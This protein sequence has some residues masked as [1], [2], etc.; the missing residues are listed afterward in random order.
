MGSPEAVARLWE[1]L[2]GSTLGPE[3]IAEFVHRDGVAELAWFSEHR[4]LRAAKQVP[5]QSWLRLSAWLAAARNVNVEPTHKGPHFDD[6]HKGRVFDPHP[7]RPADSD[8]HRRI[9]RTQRYGEET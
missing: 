4:L 7:S 8:L 5:K 6:S 9:G 3:R 1:E 2:T